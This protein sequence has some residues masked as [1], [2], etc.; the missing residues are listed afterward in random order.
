MRSLAYWK[1]YWHSRGEIVRD[2]VSKR[3]ING[4]YIVH[5]IAYGEPEFM[6][7]HEGRVLRVHRSL[8][9][10]ES[11]IKTEFIKM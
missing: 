10:A 2:V 3:R 7:C 8:E 1:R 11:S 9:A 4:M 5:E 6:V